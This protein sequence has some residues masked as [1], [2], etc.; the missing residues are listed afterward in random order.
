MYQSRNAG[1]IRLGTANFGNGYGL[2]N[3]SDS[4]LLSNSVAINLATLDVPT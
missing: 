2:S 3:S 1:V 4:A